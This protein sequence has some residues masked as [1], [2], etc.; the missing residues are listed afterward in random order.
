VE[1]DDFENEKYL[2][3][4]YDSPLASHQVIKLIESL[5][6]QGN[7]QQYNYIETQHKTFLDHLE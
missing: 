7:R 5:E 3:Q 6:A 2:K 4:L 1:K